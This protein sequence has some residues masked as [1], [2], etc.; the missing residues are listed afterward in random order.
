MQEVEQV[1]QRNSTPKTILVVDDDLDLLELLRHAVTAAGFGILTAANGVDALKLARSRSPDLIVM[2]VLL[3][4][5]DGFTLCEMLRSERATARIPIIILT[6]LTS[7]LSRFAG[8][9][10]G[11]NDYVTKPVTP[12]QLIARIELALLGSPTLG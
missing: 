12:E 1:L 8:L 6:A 2:D 11:A 9:G 4:D 10:C 5:H 7:Q 3:P